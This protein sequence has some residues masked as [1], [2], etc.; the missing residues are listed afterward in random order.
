VGTDFR[1]QPENITCQNCSPGASLASSACLWRFDTR[2]GDPAG[3][4]GVTMKSTS[5]ILG[6]LQ[7]LIPAGVQPKFTSAAELM[8]W[9]QEEGRKRAAELEK[10]NQRTRSE[11]IFGRSG[12]CDL[13]RN[14]TFANYQVSNGQKHALTLAKS[15]AH[16]FGSG[17]ASF[18]FSGCGTGKIIWLPPSVT[19]CCSITTQCWW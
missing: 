1:I 2:H 4:Q 12:I 11:K 8:A 5:D 19:T 3:I 7:R 10:E 17:F 18:V 9:Q 13:H 16:N 6:R 15:Y 14:C